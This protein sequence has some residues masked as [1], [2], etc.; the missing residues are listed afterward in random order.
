MLMIISAFLLNMNTKMGL[1]C[2][3]FPETRILMPD[4]SKIPHIRKV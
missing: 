2:K 3:E 1:H 4:V